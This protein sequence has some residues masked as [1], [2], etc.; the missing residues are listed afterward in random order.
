MR[1]DRAPQDASCPT[2]RAQ[3]IPYIANKPNFPGPGNRVKP[4]ILFQ[5]FE[6]FGLQKI[7]FEWVCF[8]PKL[9]FKLAFDPSALVLRKS[10]S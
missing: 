7:G 5:L 1:K 2:A 3:Q 4:N 10:V 6:F 9:A 8:R